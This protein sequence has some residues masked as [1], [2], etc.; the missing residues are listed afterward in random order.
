[1]L[2]CQRENTE[3]IK[4]FRHTI[5]LIQMIE[6]TQRD[7]INKKTKKSNLQVSKFS[8]LKNILMKGA[9]QQPL[10]IRIIIFNRSLQLFQ[11]LLSQ[12]IQQKLLIMLITL[13]KSIQHHKIMYQT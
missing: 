6:H 4:P 1:M 9:I 11:S 3:F 8:N 12:F 10:N 13:P 5:Q 7:P 2:F